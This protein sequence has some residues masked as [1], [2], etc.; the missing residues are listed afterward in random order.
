[1]QVLPA[2]ALDGELQQIA[3]DEFAAEVGVSEERG[4]LL[5]VPGKGTYGEGLHPS[6]TTNM[7]SMQDGA[8][9]DAT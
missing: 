9:I 8:S 6:A 5:Q 7:Q 1:M 3:V 2:G 4:T